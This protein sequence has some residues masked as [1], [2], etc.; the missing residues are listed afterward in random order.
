MPPYAW[1]LTLCTI[2]AFL[3]FCVALVVWDRSS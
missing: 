1:V 2:G 3:A